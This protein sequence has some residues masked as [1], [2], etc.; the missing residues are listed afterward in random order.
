MAALRDANGR[1]VS[2]GGPGAPVTLR[3]RWSFRGR[4]L[5][6]K[7]EQSNFQNIG[8]AAATL[9]M[10]ARR[11]IRKRKRPAPE[12]EP[13]HTQT[14]RLKTSILYA[15]DRRRESAIIGPSYHVIGVAGAEHEHGRRFRGRR[16]QQDARPFMGPALKKAAPRMPRFW[17][18][19]LVG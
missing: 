8:H 4:K 10:I 1:F 11:S 7:V 14:K 18:A 9:R 19:S 16:P 6:K 2:Q 13:P 3:G 12:G 5:Q 17:R 15:V